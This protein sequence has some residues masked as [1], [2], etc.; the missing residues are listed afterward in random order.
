MNRRQFLKLTGAAVSAALAS[1]F[2]PRS[3]TRPRAYADSEV[4]AGEWRLEGDIGPLQTGPSSFGTQALWDSQL[5]SVDSYT[6]LSPAHRAEFPFNAVGASWRAA[7]APGSDVRLAVR[8]SVDGAHWSEWQATR[9]LDAALGEKKGA[10]DL[11]FIQGRFLQCLLSVTSPRS[12]PAPMLEGLDLTYIDSSQGPEAPRPSWHTMEKGSIARL[13]RPP[14]VSRSQWGANE[15]YRFQY[16]KEIWPPTYSPARKIIVHHTASSDGGQDAAAA[17]RAI[18]YYHTVTQ[19][20][21]DIGYNFLIDRFG[22]F[23]EGRQGGPNV[24]GA[25]TAGHNAGA[26]GVAM[27]GNFQ[28]GEPPQ[29]GVNALLSFLI[30]KSVQHAIVPTGSGTFVNKVYPNIIGHKDAQSTTCPGDKLY[31]LLPTLREKAKQ[32]LPALGEAWLSHGVPSKILPGAQFWVPV[33]VA[34]SGTVAWKSS[35]STPVR[36]AYQWL[37]PDGRPYKGEPN[38]EVHI[39]LPKDVEPGNKVTFEVLLKT[40]KSP[41]K[42]RIRWDLVQQDVAWFSE[43]GNLPLDLA[44]NVSLGHSLFLP[45]VTSGR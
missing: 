24:I 4:R 40:P 6:Y 30:A 12:A 1:P 13:T 29:A 9:D 16:G 14:V 26:V 38:M 15:S 2:I 33:T 23:Y 7:L 31:A 32:G 36:L 11:V 8:A 34:N 27:I 44:V 18:Y 35:G 3:W 22:N 39:A 5:D 10:T 45:L 41:G 25:H 37:L 21:G 42:Y 17:V 19:G 43:E 28:T 20:W